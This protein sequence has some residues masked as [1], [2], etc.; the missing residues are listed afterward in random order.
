MGGLYGQ[1]LIEGGMI[2][3]WVEFSTHKLEVP[4][5]ESKLDTQ[6]VHPQAVEDVKRALGVLNT[7][8][9]K[10]TFMVGDQITLADI[11][12]ATALVGCPQ[13]DGSFQNLL[14]WHGL[15]TSQP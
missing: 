4:L 7:H 10:N 5:V 1:N 8:L 12:I 11:C 13:L 14:R 2:D 9:L 3:S 15:I 6:K